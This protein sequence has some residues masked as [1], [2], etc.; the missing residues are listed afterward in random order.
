MTTSTSSPAA[1]I[2]WK[3][4]F[5][6]ATVSK[7]SGPQRRR[8]LDLVPALVSHMLSTDPGLGARRGP[9]VLERLR[10]HLGAGAGLERMVGQM[11]AE[12]AG[13]RNGAEDAEHMAGDGMQPLAARDLALD[14]GDQC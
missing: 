4:R 2:S 1:A 8:R 9:D 14:I 13:T 3:A 7:G 10:E 6:S 5:S 11:P 12:R